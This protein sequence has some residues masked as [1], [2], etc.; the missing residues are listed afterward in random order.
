[1]KHSN[2]SVPSEVEFE[3]ALLA[4]A[5]RI[6]IVPRS[7]IEEVGLQLS[8]LNKTAQIFPAEILEISH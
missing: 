5:I 6:L 4:D 1:M 3:G 7:K 2:P 8:Q